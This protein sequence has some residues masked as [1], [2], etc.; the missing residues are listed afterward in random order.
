MIQCVLV[1]DGND[2]VVL[3][4]SGLGEENG[5]GRRLSGLKSS[6]DRLFDTPLDEV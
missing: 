5:T 4:E 2:L 6:D 1:S 3:G